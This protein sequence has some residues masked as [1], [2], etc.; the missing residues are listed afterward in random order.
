MTGGAARGSEE[1]WRRPA[2]ASSAALPAAT[3]LRATMGR[4]LRR[5]KKSRPKARVG[6]RKRTPAKAPRPVELA[7]AGAE[8]LAPK[9]GAAP[10]WKETAPVTANYSAAGLAADPNARFGRNAQRVDPLAAA[11]AA[12]GAGADC[13]S[14]DD[15][16]EAAGVKRRDG[17]A[18]PKRRLTATQAAVVAALVAAHGDDVAAMARDTK[19][20][21]MLL[22]PSKLAELL[23]RRGAGGG[24]GARHGFRAPRKSLW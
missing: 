14:D 8:A 1:W 17:K 18:A 16:R 15:L 3:L 20:N 23:K 13:P 19:L 24:E 9:L 21:R 22:P 4:S 12:L 7:V 6:V 5:A 10:A 11:A 2:N